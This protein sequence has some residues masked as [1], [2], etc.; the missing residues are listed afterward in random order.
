[1][2]SSS[3][4]VLVAAGSLRPTSSYMEWALSGLFHSALQAE[5]TYLGSPLALTGRPIFFCSSPNS[6]GRLFPLAFTA[7]HYPT[8]NWPILPCKKPSFAKPSTQ[9]TICSYSLGFSGRE[10]GSGV[11]D[12]L[13][14][15]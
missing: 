13:I 10:I 2:A 14:F 3:T 11:G 6:A 4:G 12:S 5:D 1:M 15:I 9:R 7:F 8:L